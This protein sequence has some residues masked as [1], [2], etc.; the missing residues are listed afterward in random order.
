MASRDSATQLSQSTFLV[1]Q[2]PLPRP[3][4]KAPSSSDPFFRTH[5]KHIEEKLTQW[6]E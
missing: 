4:P 2:T 1:T 5:G 3:P 6:R